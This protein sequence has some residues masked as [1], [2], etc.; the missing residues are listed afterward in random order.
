MILCS[1]CI[2]GDKGAMEWGERGER[3]CVIG[4]SG[5]EKGLGEWG[6]F[7]WGIE[8]VVLCSES[9]QQG[10]D[11]KMTINAKIIDENVWQ[12]MARSD[13]IMTMNNYQYLVTV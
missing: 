11:N 8:N 6:N 5:G 2:A 4:C 9:V 12:Q 1:I 10:D 7:E 3:V 13:A